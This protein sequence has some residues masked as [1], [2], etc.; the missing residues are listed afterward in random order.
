M[1]PPMSWL[2][3]FMRA[4][5]SHESTCD[6]GGCGRGGGGGGGGGAGG[7]G[8]GGGG[9]DGGGRGDGGGGTGK[10]GVLL[11]AITPGRRGTPSYRAGRLRWVLRLCAAQ[12]S[13]LREWPPLCT[14]S[15]PQLRVSTKE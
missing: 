1:G 10:G 6:A 8:G 13:P 4:S 14:N 11:D 2:Q 7:S 15:Q 9:G 5:P 3:A 12:A